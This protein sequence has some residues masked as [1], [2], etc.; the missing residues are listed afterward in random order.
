MQFEKKDVGYCDKLSG[1]RGSALLA[2]RK[3]ENKKLYWCH[4]ILICQI[5]LGY[6]PNKS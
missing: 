1:V 5:V 4:V 2:E 6:Y 3:G